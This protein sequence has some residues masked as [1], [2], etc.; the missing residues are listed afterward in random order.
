MKTKCLSGTY[1]LLCNPAPTVGGVNYLQQRV[2]LFT[3]TQKP[4]IL[5]VL[6]SF[7]DDLMAEEP[8]VRITHRKQMCKD[9]SA[10]RLV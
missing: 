4:N 5:H 7:T 3:Q 2:D 6:G 8:L 9:V 10:K 1:S